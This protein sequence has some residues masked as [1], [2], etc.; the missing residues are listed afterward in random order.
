MKLDFHNSTLTPASTSFFSTYHE[1]FYDRADPRI[2]DKLFMGNP[3]A[4]VLI[5]ACY[6]IFFKYFMPRIM[7]NR[8][9]VDVRNYVYA[10]HVVLFFNSFYFFQLTIR[11]WIHMDWRCQS[12]F[13][14]DA[15]ID[16]VVS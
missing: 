9:P 6:A 5:Y 1:I 16:L 4:I 7:K 13:T 15:V 8:K 11:Y 2:R 12:M 3:A 14:G 10:L